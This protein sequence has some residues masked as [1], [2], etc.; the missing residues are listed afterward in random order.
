MHLS[1]CID[2]INS[3][4]RLDYSA[5]GECTRDWIFKSTTEFYGWDDRLQQSVLFGLLCWSYTMA[6]IVMLIIQPSWTAKSS[7]PYRTFAYTLIFL[8][9]W[10]SCGRKNKLGI[11]YLFMSVLTFSF[12]FLYS[13]NCYFLCTVPRAFIFLGRLR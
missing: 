4:D 6:G 9:G 3:P 10:S 11:Y 13:S 2:L 5:A 8:Q 12:L 7:F 1:E